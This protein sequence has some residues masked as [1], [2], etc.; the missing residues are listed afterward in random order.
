[1]TGQC[2]S[3]HVDELHQIDRETARLINELLTR[4]GMLMEDASTPALLKDSCDGS[5]AKRVIVLEAEIT[6]MKSI[7]DAAKAL[8]N[9]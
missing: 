7:T 5:L 3:G 1:M 4:L 6:R 9:G 8:L 2:V